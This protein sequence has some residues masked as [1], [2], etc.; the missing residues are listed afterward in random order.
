VL[1]SW[2]VQSGF[3][4]HGPTFPGFTW[5][6]VVAQLEQPERR[7]SVSHHHSKIS[8]PDSNTVTVHIGRKVIA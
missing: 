3:W 1:P 8:R 7:S 2:T 4:E 6:P 5:F